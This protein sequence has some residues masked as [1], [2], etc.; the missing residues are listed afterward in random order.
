MHA[1][2]P[3]AVLFAALAAALAWPAIGATEPAPPGANA[4]SPAPAGAASPSPHATA[5]TAPAPTTGPIAPPAA[6]APPTTTTGPIAAP[7]APARPASFELIDRGDAVEVIARNIKAARTA[8]LPVRSRLEIPI[9]AG[10]AA[11]RVTPGDPTVKLIELDSEDAVRVLSVKLGFERAD[12]K[13]L[14]RFAQAIQVGDDLHVLVPRKLPT[15]GA[16][17]KLPDPTLSPAD[18]AAVARADLAPQL[19]LGPPPPA[20]ARADLAPPLRLGLTP[21]A[22][23]PAPLP[24]TL[25]V[26]TAVRAVD[27]TPPMPAVPPPAAGPIQGLAPAIPPAQATGAAAPTLGPAPKPALPSASD[28]ARAEAAKPTS[29]PRPLAQALAADSD[30]RWSKISMYAALG[31]AA[32]GAGVWLMRHRRAQLLPS[33]TIDVIA[34]RSLG[35]KARI[36]WL[37]AGP[38][39]M[40]VA[41]TG[42]HVRMLGQ[43]RKSEATAAPPRELPRPARA[44]LAAELPAART[45]AEARYDEASEAAEPAEPVEKPLS[46]AV[47][48]ILRLRGRTGQFPI[49]PQVNDALAPGDVEADAA[50]A[51]EILAATGARR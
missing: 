30:D 2:I 25:A 47:S 34:Q 1:M 15:D 24:A 42:Q 45:H 31:L 28:A 37:S 27:P 10:P 3:R 38:R 9:I 12:V 36:V 17:S 5:P 20:T 6:P 16:P 11:R 43:W 4:G 14:A 18:A 8:I 21:P 35:G 13:T 44:E 39:E 29:D 50:W 22:T 32:A 23:S 41:V 40:I 46:P 49:Q 48:G 7:A 51:K 33:S 19:R 26:H